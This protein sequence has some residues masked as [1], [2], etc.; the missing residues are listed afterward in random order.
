MRQQHVLPNDTFVIRNDLV[1]HILLEELLAEE[2]V[3]KLTTTIPIIAETHC[4]VTV[5]KDDQ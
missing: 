3:R 1:K 5:G 4:C 2:F